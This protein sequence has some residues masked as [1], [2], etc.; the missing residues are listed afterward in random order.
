MRQQDSP[1]TQGTL[2]RT[3][4][5]EGRAPRHK[6]SRP[7]LNPHVFIREE[8]LKYLDDQLARGSL[9][10]TGP[11]GSGK[12]VL[13]SSY[14]K[15][16]KI[17][18]SWYQL[19]IIDSDPA[20]FFSL[21]PHSLTFRKKQSPMLPRFTPETMLQF[22]I[23]CRKFFRELFRD[24]SEASV[25]VLDNYQEIVETSVVHKA[26][27]IMVEELP[28]ESRLMILSR[29][30]PPKTFARAR[31]NHLLQVIEEDRFVFSR[32]EVGALLQLHGIS[33]GDDGL[34]DHLHDVTRGWA[35]GLTLMLEELDTQDGQALAI[36]HHGV[37]FD[38]FADV[39]FRRQGKAEQ[40]MLLKASVLQEL[41]VKVV[42]NLCQW[43]GAGPYLQELSEKNY[44]TYRISKEQKTYQF[45]PLFRAFLAKTAEEKFSE[46]TL[47]ALRRHGA[48]LLRESGSVI[49]SIE[50]LFE[51]EDWTACT[52]LIKENAGVLFQRAHFGTVFRWLNGIPEER[53]I[54]DPWLLCH[55]GVA[56]MP[57]L[58]QV[59]IECLQRSFQNFRT[60]GD[61]PGALFCCP[62]L[63]R[64]I[65][66]FM[67]DMSAMDPLI[68]FI[69]Q[70]VDVQELHRESD[71]RHDQLVLAMFRALVSRRPDH[72]EIELWAEIVENLFQKGR[73]M[74]GPVLPLHYLWTGRFLEAEDALTRMLGM[75]E[76]M[77]TSPLDFTGVLSLKLQYHLVMGQTEECLETVRRGLQAVEET[78]VKIW[79]NHY[80][81][82]GAACR[83]NHGETGRAREFIG[84]VEENLTELRGLDFSYYHLVKAFYSLLTG[85]KREA[86]YHGNRAL[87]EGI[88]LCMP[89]YEN[90]CRLGNGVL[91]VDRRDYGTATEHFDRIFQLCATSGNPWFVCQAHLGMALVH[92]GREEKDE[93][94]KRAQK[95]FSL[96]KKYDYQ[97]FFFFPRN[98]LTALCAL[99]QE[100]AIETTFVCSFIRRW[101]LVP[102]SPCVEPESWP[103]PLKIF[104][105]GKF[106]VE[107]NGKDLIA[108][109]G[110]KGK[111]LE[112]LRVLISSGGN[113]VAETRIQ[114]ILW[115]DSEGDKQSR[116]LKTTLYRLRKLLGL[117]DAIIHADRSLSINRNCCW[118]DTSI[119]QELDAM[120]R[121]AAAEEKSDQLLKLSG[122]VFNL[123]QGPF[124][125]DRPDEEWTFSLRA[126]FVRRFRSLVEALGNVLEE[127]KEWASAD[128]IYQEAIS[129]DPSW[130]HFHRRRMGCLYNMGETSKALRVYEECEERLAR[131]SKKPSPQT[132]A[133]RDRILSS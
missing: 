31:A 42:E 87:E 112:L 67:T 53:V 7:R 32:K 76:H 97:A 75:K 130:E 86:A 129:R 96:A 44:F 23:F 101:K 35:A 38:Y 128:R 15:S 106:R 9:W 25:I 100:N 13:A 95:G 123:Y 116:S 47:V 99:A 94:I 72:S 46:E 120:V 85:E 124:L 48:E 62:H 69:H 55:K 121:E 64:A 41:D 58:P 60:K 57:F 33:A 3:G 5:Q 43:S 28:P 102:K 77:E 80:Y 89:S 74:P 90:W 115:P 113:Q 59:S 104:A 30:W 17:A 111:P 36:P 107:S 70:H 68:D 24:L 1:E 117:K 105:L 91:A 66:S 51:V 8:L 114:D 61:I 122:I 45:H 82:L 103:W 125:S 84:E 54:S 79:K 20:S 132:R 133:L 40:D 4:L 27:E 14:L 11:P 26:L 6:I 126:D 16:R 118:V 65:L 88:R 34:A 56:A 18:A 119:F 50:L 108:S 83:L 21:F 22:E 92:L 37:V 73:L 127:K 63:C 131:L 110:G 109:F 71:P 19:D 39:V 49:E 98:M 2:E 10:L 52:A 81:L 78:G 93:A 12:T 29:G